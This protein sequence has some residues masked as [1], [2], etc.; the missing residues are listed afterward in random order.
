MTPAPSLKKGGEHSVNNRVTSEI[1][2]SFIIFVKAMRLTQKSNL[3]KVKQKN[4]GNMKLCKAID[5]L[6]SLIEDK[7][8][9]SKEDIL[10]DRPDADQVHSDG[11]YFFD[12]SIHRTLML[13]ELSDDG[14]A[15]IIW[16]GT[17]DD[18]ERIFKNSKGII[19]KYLSERGWI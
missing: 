17:H 7:S 13:L 11:F 14:E 5:E 18:Y 3:L 2:R 8:W 19:K 4:K 16:A 9:K 6:I 1:N 15:T 10:R 12:I